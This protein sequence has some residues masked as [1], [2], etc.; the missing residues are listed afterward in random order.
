M[1]FDALAA[2][3]PAMAV[4]LCGLFYADYALTIWGQKLY[5]AFGRE[6]QVHEAYEMNPDWRDAVAQGRYWHPRLLV[7]FALYTVIAGLLWA[8]AAVVSWGPDL[9]LGGAMALAIRDAMLAVVISR[10]LV[11]IG[12][13]L[14]NIVTYSRLMGA[15][16]VTGCTTYSAAFSYAMLRAHALIASL[17]FAVLFA[18]QP[19]A[20][21]AGFALGPASLILQVRRM[22]EKH[23]KLAAPADAAVEADAVAQT[24][25]PT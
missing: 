5:L 16:F 11:I 9:G 1:P 23:R 4:L 22:E 14:R 3:F 2:N 19:T 25:S 17:P 20:V 18:L 15:D 7:A 21:H 10:S 13:H 6:H 8:M 12:L 24:S